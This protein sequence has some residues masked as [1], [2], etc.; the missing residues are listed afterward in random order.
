MRYQLSLSL[1]A[2]FDI[3][4]AVDYYE[5]ERTGLGDRFR[6]EA[7]QLLHRLESNPYLYP[8][9]HIPPY[10]K[11]TLTIFPFCIFYKIANSE[12]IVIAVHHSRRDPDLWHAR[13]KA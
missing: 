11:A 4:D 8:A 9:T 2:V 13:T 10:R 7:M 12:I 5:E 1:W 3:A 6:S